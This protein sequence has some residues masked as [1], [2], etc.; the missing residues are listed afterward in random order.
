MR[1]IKFRAWDKKYKEMLYTGFQLN[2]I[3]NVMST[4]NFRKWNGERNNN[5]IPLQYTGIKDKNGKDIYEGDIVQIK[6]PKHV[7]NNEIAEVVFMKGFF[8][9]S[10]IND[11]EALVDYINEYKNDLV[12]IGNIYENPELLEGDID[13]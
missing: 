5:L 7:L 2:C 9:L 3:G 12:I 13:E 10:W 6:K 8:G 1:E 4:F 11:R